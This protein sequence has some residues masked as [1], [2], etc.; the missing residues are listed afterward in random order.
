MTPIATGER[1][2]AAA[3]ARDR[4]SAL[5]FGP[6]SSAAG[7]PEDPVLLEQVSGGRVAIITLN[8]PTDNAITTEM[9]ARLTEVLETIAVSHPV[10]VVHH[11]RR[12]HGPSRSA[13]ICANART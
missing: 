6:P 12:R 10:R 2:D 11:H 4:W 7:E 8:R 13:A 3:G 9:G 1:H 5:D